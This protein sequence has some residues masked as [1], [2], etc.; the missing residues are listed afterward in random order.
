MYPSVSIILLTVLQILL[1]FCFIHYFPRRKLQNWMRVTIC[2]LDTT[3]SAAA[4]SQRKSHNRPDWL[5]HKPAITSLKWCLQYCLISS[6]FSGWAPS[7]LCSPQWLCLKFS[8]LLK[9][10][11]SVPKLSKSPFHKDEGTLQRTWKSSGG[12]YMSLVSDKYL[13][14]F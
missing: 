3:L 2:F 13:S 14:M 8:I 9:S 7:L 5:H 6:P 1:P 10:L 12:I 11:S 4:C